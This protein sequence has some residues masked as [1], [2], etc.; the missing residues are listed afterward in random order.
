MGLEDGLPLGKTG[1]NL[2]LDPFRYIDSIMERK[3]ICLFYEEPE[4][5]RMIEFR[6]IR[7]GLALD[8]QCVYA[9]DEDSGSVMLRMLTYGI[10]LKYFQTGRLKIHQIQKVIGNTEEIM[11]D[12]KRNIGILLSGLSM[13]FR[14]VSRIV[15]DVSTMTRMAVELELERITHQAFEA[16][17]GSL[18]CPYD[19]SKIEHTRKK[20]WMEKLCENHHVVIYAPRFG[21]GSVFGCQELQK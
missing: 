2:D 16:F 18:I 8:E 6:F 12:C 5:A 9:T 11:D 19:I 10:P 3:H 15:A 1:F 20:E 7:N 14:M 4:Y 13:P 17:G 21:E